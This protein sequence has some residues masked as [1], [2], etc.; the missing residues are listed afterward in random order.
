MTTVKDFFAD[1]YRSLFVIFSFIITIYV[2]HITNTS[3][4]AELT[5]RCATL[6]VK[7]EDQ[8]DKINAIK[9]DKA[10]FEATMTQFVSIQT[11]LREMRGDIKELL[12]QR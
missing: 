9:L 3:R 2:Q 4:I 10:V 6:E 7:I 12:K 11:D 1:N 5:E 8:Y